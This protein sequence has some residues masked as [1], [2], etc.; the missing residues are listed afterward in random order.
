MADM[1]DH[2]LLIRIDER[3]ALTD[4]RLETMESRAETEINK[5][6]KYNEKQ[7]D[8]IGSLEHWRWYTFGCLGCLG[9]LGFA[10]KLW[11]G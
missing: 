4:R 5:A 3:T 1:T 10:L 11:I 9:G 7:D 2:D 6:A 8:R